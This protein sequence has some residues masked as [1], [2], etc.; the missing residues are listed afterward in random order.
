MR[1]VWPVLMLIFC[2]FFLMNVQ[3]ATPVSTASISQYPPDITAI[4]KS[5]VL[6]VA[7]VSENAPPFFFKDAQGNWSGIDIDLGRMTA[8]ALGVKLVIV[9]VPT[10]DAVID[11]V[12]NGKAD[13]GAGLLSVTP[14]RALRV[15]FS[16]A[17]YAYHPS[18]L[19]NRMQMNRLNW[20]IMNVVANLQATK[21]VLKIG[22]LE[23]SSNI[24]LLQGAAPSAEII[25]FPT[26]DDALQAVAEGKV[27]AAMSD[28][29]EQMNNWLSAHPDAAFKTI[30][31]VLSSRSVLFGV[32]MSWK[33]ENLREFLNIYLKDLES[34]NVQ[35][36]LFEKYGVEDPG[37]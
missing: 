1:V 37:A 6:R 17:T 30:Q 27:F 25:S 31:G 7:M 2:G 8:T 24:G 19:I 14:N 28:T 20:N 33:A 3:A 4:K 29:P 35:K 9:S 5:G 16:D 26:E 18:L 11:A 36:R 22:A 10:Y 23:D 12:V 32:A 13:L 21:Q 15:K 34:M